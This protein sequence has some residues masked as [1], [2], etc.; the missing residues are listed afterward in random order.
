MRTRLERSGSVDYQVRRSNDA[1]RDHQARTLVTASL[2]AWLKP[3][4]AVDP[5]CGD[6]SILMTADRLYPIQHAHFGDISEPNIAHLIGA[7]GY[8]GRGW[9][10]RMADAIAT[11]SEAPPSD[12]IVLTEFLEH[13]EDPDRILSLAKSKA[14]Y[15]V[16]SSPVMRDGQV[17]DNP[18]HL[19]MFDRAGYQG[20]LV[21]AGWNVQQYTWLAFP[22]MY[23]F[24]IWVCS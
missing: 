2:V 15:L 11:V 24:G 3:T 13:I 9:S 4:R 17:D 12:V 21:K 14:R 5:A 1:W 23:D 22:T 16:A 19:W 20:M 6:G 10:F 8:K 18:E 7:T